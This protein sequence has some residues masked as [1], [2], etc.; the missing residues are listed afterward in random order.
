MKLFQFS[1]LKIKTRI[2]IDKVY[3][4]NGDQPIGSNPHELAALPAQHVTRMNTRSQQLSFVL[5]GIPSCCS[6]G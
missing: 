4:L 2:E 3:S 6:C 5:N 1:S